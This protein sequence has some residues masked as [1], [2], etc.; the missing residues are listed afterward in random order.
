[1]FHGADTD[2]LRAWSQTAQR[3][4]LTLEALLGDLVARAASVSWTGPDRDAFTQSFN[5][6]V[7]ARGSWATEELKRRSSDA[8]A[9]AEEQDTAS[10]AESSGTN[11]DSSGQDRTP[12]STTES[13]GALVDAPDRL[14]Q[15]V[16]DVEAIRAAGEGIKQGL[17]GDC[18]FLAPL[19]ALAQTD[20]SFLEEGIRYEDGVYKVRFYKRGLFGPQEVWIDVDPSVAQH[21]ARGPGGSITPLSLY[22]TAYAQFE[23]G[24]EDIEG[25]RAKNAMYA[26]TGNADEMDTEPSVADLRTAMDE[27]KVIVADTGPREGESFIGG[28]P[29]R[30][31]PVPK[32]GVSN[33]VYVVQE[34]RD[35]GTIVLQNPWG[36]QGGTQD[37]ISRPG[38]L[39][40]T[41]AEYREMFQHVTIGEVPEG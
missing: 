10:S 13:S 35:D 27:G 2:Q 33:H 14:Q 29:D 38:R 31:G 12:P 18:F 1:M 5:A 7:T 15:E 30:D 36:P 37:G 4:A 26:L 34:I 41:E 23:G 25:G 20:P 11:A 9:E 21:G 39:E 24:F 8:T 19:A 22:E 32:D 28:F 40:L 16:D 17:I 3:S 6:E